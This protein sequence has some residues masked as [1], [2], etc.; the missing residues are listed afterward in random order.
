MSPSCEDRNLLIGAFPYIKKD[1]S[2]ELILKDIEKNFTDR[3]IVNIL[4]S[5]KKTYLIASMKEGVG[6]SYFSEKLTNKLSDFSQKIC[7]LDLDL[8]K[9]GISND[10][11]FKNKAISYDEYLQQ[12]SFPNLTFI[13]KPKVEDPLT[14]LNS[15]FLEELIIK[16]KRDFDKV[17]IDSPP[18]GTFIDSKIISNKV[19]QIICILSSHE[20]SFSEIS[21]MTSEIKNE[22]SPEIIFFLNKVR[23]FL[24][25]F[26]FN[27]R[28]PL[29]GNYNYYNPYSYYSN[30]EPKSFRNIKKYVLFALEKL[31]YGFKKL[32]NIVLAFFKK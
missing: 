18:M 21:S 26:W 4:N 28:Y 9:K 3:A 2:N 16:L 17:L 12:D 31:N 1:N 32:K 30:N 14:F 15:P 25:I 8:R 20:S 7:L 5:N 11:F 24:E 29:Y 23:Y 19:D 10:E 22:G 27:V 13:S 6:K